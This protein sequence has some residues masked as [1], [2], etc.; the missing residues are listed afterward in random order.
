MTNIRRQTALIAVLIVLIACAGWFAKMFNDK[1]L[2]TQVASQTKKEITNY[3]AENRMGRE[4]KV[5]AL[6]QE[7]EK[8]INSEDATEDTKTQAS[9][10]YMNLLSRDN[11]ESTIETKTKDLGFDDA[12]CFINDNGIELCVKSTPDAITKDQVLKMTDIIVTVTGVSPSSIVIT[13]KEK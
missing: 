9:A 13:G 4:N 10:K 7:Y 11:N 3:F 2:G 1:E 5:S 12:I 8:I 6:K